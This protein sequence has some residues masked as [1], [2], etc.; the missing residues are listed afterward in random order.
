MRIVSFVVGVA[1]SLIV[2]AADNTKF[3]DW[4]DQLPQP[5]FDEKPEL[6]DFYCKA[7]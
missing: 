6:V 3:P 1:I 7:W 5:V 2:A 4:K